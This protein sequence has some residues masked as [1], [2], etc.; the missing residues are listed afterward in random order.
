MMIPKEQPIRSQKLRRS[1][2]GHPCTMR[3][4]D[5]CNGDPETS[6]LAHP[7]VANGGMAWKASDEMGAI[8]CSA[9]H[10]CVDGRD[11][12]WVPR[13]LLLECWIRGHQ[14]TLTYWRQMG[15]LSVRGAA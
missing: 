7:C 5:V 6:V 3:I 1:A 12:T 13:S 15:L 8:A 4:P 14:E 11:H 2:Q 10:D 9:C